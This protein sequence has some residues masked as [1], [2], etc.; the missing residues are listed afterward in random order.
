MGKKCSSFKLL[1]LM[2]VG[3][4]LCLAV[5][6]SQ[7]EVREI[8]A[9]K[10]WRGR[11]ENNLGKAAPQ[12]GYLV[13]QAELDHLWTA[14]RIADKPAVDFQT[15]LVLVR[16]CNC[17][18]ISIAPLLN[19]EGDLNI[20]VTMTKDLREDTAYCLVLIPRRGIRTVQGKALEIY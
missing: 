19:E 16:T 10:E 4:L 9:L 17:S 1:W 11:V 12:R 6:I 5:S 2:L 7:A 3:G 8:K 13:S 18:L 15:Q 20:Q 14:W